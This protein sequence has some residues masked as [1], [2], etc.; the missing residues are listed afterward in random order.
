MVSG[1]VSWFQLCTYLSTFFSSNNYFC[2]A[3]ILLYGCHVTVQIA[4]Q[5]ESVEF[6][7]ALFEGLVFLL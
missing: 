6:A 5:A 2:S 7:P 3:H 4:V 1:S